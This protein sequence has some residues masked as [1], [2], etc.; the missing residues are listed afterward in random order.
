MNISSSEIKGIVKEII[1]E[2][3]SV[4]FYLHQHPEPSFKEFNT[5]DYVRDK[6]ISWGLSPLTGIAGTGL[7]V[8]IEGKNPSSHTVALRADMDALPIQELSD[9]PY[10][11]VNEGFMHACGHDVHTACLLGAVKVLNELKH[12]FE[13]TVKAVFQPGE[14]LLPGGASMMIADGALKNPD[15]N[16]IFGQHVFPDLPVGKAGFKQGQYMASCDEIYMTVRGSGGHGAMPHRCV[17]DRKSTRLNS[18]HS[19]RSRMPSSA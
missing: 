15:V 11:S 5:A 1:T 6:L 10:K 19:D 9:V 13:G 14:E 7:L 8:L 18:S 3:Q 2:I 12:K 4:R 17:E 16:V